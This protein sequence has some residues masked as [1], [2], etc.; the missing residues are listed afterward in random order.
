LSKTASIAKKRTCSEFSESKFEN[1][2]IEIYTTAKMYN[3]PNPDARDTRGK[4]GYR[5]YW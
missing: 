2:G 4:R 3:T 5:Q 1:E